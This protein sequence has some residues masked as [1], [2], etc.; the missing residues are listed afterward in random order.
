MGVIWALYKVR[1]GTRTIELLLL[2]PVM[3]LNDLKADASMRCSSDVDGPTSHRHIATF[4]RR[5]SR[6]LSMG[7]GSNDQTMLK[8]PER[9]TTLPLAQA[10]MWVPV[11]PSYGP[12]APLPFG[13]SLRVT[14][15]RWDLVLGG[16]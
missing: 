12:A 16:H 4:R 10:R 5:I 8:S 11:P 15:P 1:R 3:L 6:T 14:V 9:P 7:A 2:V 13:S